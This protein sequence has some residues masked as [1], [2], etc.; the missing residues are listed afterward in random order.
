MQHHHFA[1]LESKLP[2]SPTIT[3]SLVENPKSICIFAVITGPGRAVTQEYG[4]LFAFNRS[5]SFSGHCKPVQRVLFMRHLSGSYDSICFQKI[6]ITT[7]IGKVAL[8]GPV[9]VLKVHGLLPSHSPVSYIVLEGIQSSPS[10]PAAK[11]SPRP[12]LWW[13]G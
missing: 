5:C 7:I 1:L 8:V 13:S 10:A 3:R 2:F 6:L 11:H 4:P 9:D 12:I